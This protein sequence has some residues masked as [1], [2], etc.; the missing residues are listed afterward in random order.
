MREQRREVDAAMTNHFH[1][2][3]HSLFAPRTKRRHDPVIAYASRE[4]FIRNLK[5]AG[6][7]T[8]TGQGSCRSQAAQR[9]LE[10]LLSAQ[11]LDCY[12]RATTCQTFYFSHNID[13]AIVERDI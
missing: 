8:E 13:I 4:R 6:I 11:R 2:P 1:Q 7:D 5:F 12:I 10:C 9:A 3:A